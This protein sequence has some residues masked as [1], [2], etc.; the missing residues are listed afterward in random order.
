MLR[1]FLNT[2]QLLGRWL[3]RENG[4]LT[5]EALLIF[6]LFV[7]TVSLTYTFYDGFR[8]STANLKAAY[9][10]SDLISREKDGINDTYVSSM[11]LLMQRMVNNESE[12]RMRLSF[13][14]YKEDEDRLVVDWSTSCGF[15]ETWTNVNIEA[16]RDR[17]PPLSDL[18][19]LIIV[20]TV[21]NYEWTIKP[22]WM[23]TDYRFENFIFTRPR[24]AD[25][26]SAD[27]L[28]EQGC[29]A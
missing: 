22:P 18:E 4:A 17:L 7:Y 8:Q 25:Q 6:P 14:R 21:N 15:A 26:I 2:R 12:M 29:T 24:I 13:I 27:N 5:V 23:N 16:L 3:R 1:V 9:T 20:E 11:H 28:S 19:P 10:V